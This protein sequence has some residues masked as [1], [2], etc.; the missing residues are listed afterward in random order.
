MACVLSE[1]ATDTDAEDDAAD[2]GAT[3][4]A[5][6]VH[7]A[8]HGVVDS[9]DDFWTSRKIARDDRVKV[10]VCRGTEDFGGQAALL[11]TLLSLTASVDFVWRRAGFFEDVFYLVAALDEV[12]YTEAAR[13]DVGFLPVG[14][15]GYLGQ[16]EHDVVLAAHDGHHRVLCHWGYGLSVEK[17]G[18]WGKE[19]TDDLQKAWFSEEGGRGKDVEPHRRFDD[20]A[21]ALGATEED[22]SWTTEARVVEDGEGICAG[23][24]EEGLPL[25]FAATEEEVGDD[26][27]ASQSVTLG[28]GTLEG[29]HLHAA[30]SLYIFG[31]NDGDP[32]GLCA[33]AVEV[34]EETG[35][36]TGIIAGVDQ[37]PYDGVEGLA[38]VK[39]LPAEDVFHIIVEGSVLAIIEQGPLELIE[40]GS[41]RHH[42][43]RRDDIEVFFLVNGSSIPP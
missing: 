27:Q 28:Q 36:L 23:G 11:G 32:V 41:G 34:G 33:L 5:L 7:Q 1:T 26:A 6:G 9:L 31:L 20:E 37:P 2:H 15:A 12:D 14:Q 16:G 18:P 30:Q 22:F 40:G 43:T 24:I 38:G 21:K 42:E 39:V 3:S 25:A 13:M 29:D 8:F 19:I 17:G 4:G 35:G 10:D